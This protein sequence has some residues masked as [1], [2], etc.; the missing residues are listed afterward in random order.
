[1]FKL[2][3]ITSVCIYV[4]A[5]QSAYAQTAP[6]PTD[7][8]RNIEQNKQVL[9]R[10]E[11]KSGTKKIPA[12]TSISQD[13]ASLHEIRIQSPLFQKELMSY[14]LNELSKP[15]S[16]QKLSDFK[17]FAWDLF[18]NKGYLAY[19]TTGTKNTPE[20]SVLSVNVAFPKVAKVSV[21]AIE[22]GSKEFVDEVARRFSSI[23]KTGMPVDIQGYENQLSAASYDL[24][25][26]LEMRMRQV[27][28]S[29]V[30]VVIHLRPIHAEPGTVLGGVMQANNYGLA[31][32]GQSQILGNIR[33]AGFTPSSELTLTTQQSDG[34]GYYRADYEAPV[35]GTRSRMRLFS[36]QV[37]SVATNS[38][39]LSNEA[40]VGFT[41][42]LQ[43]DRHGRWLAGPEVSHRETKNWGSGVL[44]SDRVDQQIRLKLR[45]ES[46]NSWVDNF[47]NE[48]SLSIGRVN[49]DRLNSD[50]LDDTTSGLNV[51]GT[52]QKLEMTGLLSQT[53]DRERIYTGSIRWKAQA[54]SKNLDGYNRMSLGGINGIRAYS[55]IDGVGDQGAQM[56]FDIIHQVVPDVFGGLFYDV[57]VVKNN[58]Q[59]IASATDTSAY[60]LQ[61]A[62]W[63]VGG[64]INQYNWT[65]SAAHAF[66]KTPGPGVWTSANTQ[67]GDFRV[68]FAV[69]R[70]F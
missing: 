63:Q 7:A 24:P 3:K 17:S 42:L 43:T 57:G 38:K 61:G 70:P 66:G 16:A 58:H 6:S 44:T 65:L 67:T 53:L 22:G 28:E 15:V 55:S 2:R 59:P 9:K 30:D 68:N 10:N 39:G 62:G 18:Q 37:K 14:W 36:S 12:P 69:T 52:Y 33:V 48:F 25:V 41:T 23:Y 4:A 49:L 8:L 56:S 35:V 54:A 20:G 13:I 34:V 45:A 40:G 29:E 19:I 50:K 26:D 32:F 5:M 21:V 60:L 47:N 64:R 51:A 46:S 27:N 31:Q 1:M 11:S